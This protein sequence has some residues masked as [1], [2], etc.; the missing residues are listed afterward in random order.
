MFCSIPRISTSVCVYSPCGHKKRHWWI[1]GKNDGHL[2]ANKSRD[3]WPEPSEGEHAG[4]SR[5][6]KVIHSENKSRPS[7]CGKTEIFHRAE[8]E[9]WVT[10]YVQVLELEITLHL[11]QRAL[12]VVTTGRLCRPSGLNPWSS[13][14]ASL[15]SGEPWRPWPLVCPMEEELTK[16]RE[17]AVQLLCSHTDIDSDVCWRSVY[18]QTWWQK[19]SIIL[20]LHLLNHSSLWCSDN[21]CL[22]QK[23]RQWDSIH[24]YSSHQ[25]DK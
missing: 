6:Y 17:A 24:K 4:F 13:P 2:A 20:T 12:C 8:T 21:I 14:E 16:A 18:A 15:G 23:M 25:I 1:K 11:C 22:L 9:M 3:A 19:F 7:N 10:G 5:H